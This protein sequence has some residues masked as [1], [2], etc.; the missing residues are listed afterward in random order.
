MVA[1]G[2]M[3]ARGS[4]TPAFHD[5]HQVTD[6]WQVTRLTEFVQPNMQLMPQRI[7]LF[8]SKS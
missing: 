7:V 4:E 2:N 8:D 6:A 3:Q 5:A 1:K